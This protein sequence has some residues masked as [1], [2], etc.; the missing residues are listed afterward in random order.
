MVLW[1]LAVFPSAICKQLVYVYFAYVYSLYWQKKI[2]L[3]KKK[4][5]KNKCESTLNTLINSYQ[6]P[7]GRFQ[8]KSVNTILYKLMNCHQVP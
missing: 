4:K 7:R 5:K 6:V 1:F 2:G 8:F 3:N